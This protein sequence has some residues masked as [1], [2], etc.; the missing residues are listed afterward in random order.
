MYQLSRRGSLSRI[1]WAIVSVGNWGRG[2]GG[3]V[4]GGRRRQLLLLPPSQ[5]SLN[6]SQASRMI[7]V[8]EAV[9]FSAAE[10]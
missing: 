1:M 5:S 4:C 7:Y 8:P 10:V 3:G 6:G 2:R 9:L